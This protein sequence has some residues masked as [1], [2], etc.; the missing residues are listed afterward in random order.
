MI[1]KE[2]DALIFGIWKLGI[3]KKSLL[4]IVEAIDE[5]Q[6]GFVTIGE[7]RDVLKRYAKD[8][9]SAGKE[10]LLRRH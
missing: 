9:R 8:F 7:V 3:P 5:D 10:K 6:D 4:A 1:L 2:A